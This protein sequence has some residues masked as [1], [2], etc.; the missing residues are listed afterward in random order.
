MKELEWMVGQWVDEDENATIET[1]CSWTP[2]KAFLRRSF[3]VAVQNRVDLAGLQVIGWDADAEMLRSW[4]FDSAGGFANEEWSKEGDR[5]IVKS[6]GVLFG[7][8]KS[9]AVRIITP[10]D[11]DSFTLEAVGRE[12][13]GELLP[14]IDKVTVVRQKPSK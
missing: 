1:T 2:N 13:G 9:S 14:D 12:V 6:A 7:G 5:W 8:Q 4:I 11:E 10:I 3:K